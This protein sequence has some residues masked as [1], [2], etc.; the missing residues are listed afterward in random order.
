VDSKATTVNSLEASLC[1]FVAKLSRTQLFHERS[2]EP[3]RGG[4]L[5]LCQEQ[6]TNKISLSALVPR[7]D[8]F[9]LRQDVIQDKCGFKYVYIHRFCCSMTITHVDMW[10]LLA[11]LIDAFL[12]AS[13]C[14]AIR[15]R[16][17]ILP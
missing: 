9:K 15:V 8:K 4:F 7:L 13:R 6:S 14:L 17:A 11:N 16:V 5:F 10:W 12:L 1:F 2:S 3:D